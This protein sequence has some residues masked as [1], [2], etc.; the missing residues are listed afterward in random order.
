MSNDTTPAAEEAAVVAEEKALTGEPHAGPVVKSH[1]ADVR[2][3]LEGQGYDV[4]TG[5]H[6]SAVGAL[7]DALQSEFSTMFGGAKISGPED[8]WRKAAEGMLV[9]MQAV[10]ALTSGGDSVVI[11]VPSVTR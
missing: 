6:E 5:A 1:E 11:V 10:S 9:K 4:T 3:G 2:R 7:A 8:S